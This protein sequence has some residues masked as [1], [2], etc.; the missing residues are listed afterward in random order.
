MRFTSAFPNLKAVKLESRL[1]RIQNLTA[2]AVAAAVEAWTK[3][4]YVMDHAN[5]LLERFPGIEVSFDLNLEPQT[6]EVVSVESPSDL[7]AL[8]MIIEASAGVDGE[9][10]ETG[11][12]GE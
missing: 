10:E 11:V 5:A 8:L 1:M 3:R 7:T 4:R 12:T 6:E 2:E 9:G